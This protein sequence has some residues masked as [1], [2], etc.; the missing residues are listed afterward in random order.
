MLAEMALLTTTFSNN[1][2][3]ISDQCSYPVSLSAGKPCQRFGSKHHMRGIEQPVVLPVLERRRKI[4]QVDGLGKILQGVMKVSGFFR[5]VA[6]KY[7]IQ[8][9]GGR[10]QKSRSGN[11]L[12]TAASQVRAY[13]FCGWAKESLSTRLKRW[14]D[15]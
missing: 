11:E 12:R 8:L 2:F 14:G 7:M 15:D 6:D 1:S 10:M 3:G 9:G 4:K 13:N 5:V